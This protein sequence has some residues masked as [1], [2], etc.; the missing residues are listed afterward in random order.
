MV[1]AS[2]MGKHPVYPYDSVML[3][4]TPLQVRKAHGATSSFQ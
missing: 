3:P 2:Q 1:Q 4:G